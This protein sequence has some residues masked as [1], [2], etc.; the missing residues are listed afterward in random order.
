MAKLLEGGIAKL[1]AKS[2]KAAKMTMPATL[3]KV[4]AGTRAP[5]AVSG[6]TNP[7][8]ASFAA[9]G[10]VADRTYRLV[11]GVSVQANDRVYALLGATIA[12]GQRPVAN[13]RLTIDGETYR[14]EAVQTDPA[15]AVYIC[16]AR[17]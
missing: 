15:R 8:E 7:T 16:L 13:D 17:K 3:I 9:K 10:F 2:L 14:L 11:D 5:D 6:G 1:V 4:T 12:S